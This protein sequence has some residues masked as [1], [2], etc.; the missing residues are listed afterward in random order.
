MLGNYIFLL[1]PLMI[2]LLCWG[3]YCAWPDDE[4]LTTLAEA[5]RWRIDRRNDGVGT[6]G[7]CGGDGGGGGS[8]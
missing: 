8:C 1:F 3:I 2:G 6:D 5:K 7:A 4:A